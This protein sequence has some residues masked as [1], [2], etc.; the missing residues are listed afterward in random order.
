MKQIARAAFLLLA[1]IP[2]PVMAKSV[3]EY[4][5]VDHRYRS[6]EPAQTKAAFKSFCR[7]VDGV[8]G[9]YDEREACT[10]LLHPEEGKTK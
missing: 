3:C 7:D 2:V 4:S 9:A 5:G 10:K 1:M 8:R 6:C